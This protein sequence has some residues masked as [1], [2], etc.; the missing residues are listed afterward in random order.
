MR[1][2]RSDSPIIGSH[3]QESRRMPGFSGPSYN[4]QA[5]KS[6]R[7][8]CPLI[9]LVGTESYPVSAMA[10]YPKLSDAGFLSQCLPDATVVEATPDRAEWKQKPKLSFITGSLD[11]VLTV[12]GRVPGES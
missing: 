4:S 8:R 12:T 1:R 2:G 3:L 10:L 6:A 9:Q 7:P 11:T 5:N